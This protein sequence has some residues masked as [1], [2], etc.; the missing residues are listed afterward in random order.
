[1]PPSNV[2]RTM[3]FNAAGTMVSTVSAVYLATVV[4]T[5]AH[6]AL[7]KNFPHLYADI[8]QQ[9]LPTCV[10][11]QEVQRRMM[12]QPMKVVNEISLLAG[13][14]THTH[15]ERA[16]YYYY[17]S[18]STDVPIMELEEAAPYHAPP[19]SA[20]DSASAFSSELNSTRT[21]L[22]EDTIFSK[23][24]AP[25]SKESSFSTSSSLR[26]RL[27]NAS[28]KQTAESMLQESL[29]NIAMTA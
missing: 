4:E 15:E 21:L 8:P 27:C 3:A 7:H 6:K 17:G 1:M 24:Y 28:P 19:S 22:G 9:D 13:E 16:S 29:L 18:A 20:V 25:S 11:N 26:E 14:L 10:L 12:K 2:L 23:D 5:S